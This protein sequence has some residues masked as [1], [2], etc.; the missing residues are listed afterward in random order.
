MARKKKQ[1]ED[2]I[3]TG[4]RHGGKVYLP[5]DEDELKE[6]NLSAESLNHL[7]VN[8]AIVGFGTEVRPK[9][10]EIVEGDEDT[11]T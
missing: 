5:G 4:V 7:A 6:L 8:G 3:L 1:L 2:E 11:E 10:V 9:S